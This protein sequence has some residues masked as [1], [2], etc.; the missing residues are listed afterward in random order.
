MKPHDLEVEYRKVSEISPDPGNAKIHNAEQ[1]EQIKKSIEEFGFN[2]PIAIDENGEIIEGH[3][4]LLAAIDLGMQEVP[5]I[6]LTGLTEQEKA[7]YGLVHNKLTMN[8]PFD[9]EILKMELEDIK[10]ID[11]SDF[12]FNLHEDFFSDDESTYETTKNEKIIVI[13]DHIKADTIRD[14]LKK[15]KIKFKEVV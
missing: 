10:D 6:T 8:T 4:R 5:V 15:Q 1:I 11:M 13:V 7:A 14:Y 9:Y 12:S 2:D 3:G